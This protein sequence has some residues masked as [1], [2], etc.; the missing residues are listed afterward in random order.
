M[1]SVPPEAPLQIQLEAA[2]LNAV[3]KIPISH[4]TAG[5]AMRCNLCGQVFHAEKLLEF[6]THIPVPQ[7]FD[8]R[9]ACPNC[10]PARGSNGQ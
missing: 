3:P 2:E 4:F 1:A 8:Y 5:R 9:V 10:H 7:G 6:D